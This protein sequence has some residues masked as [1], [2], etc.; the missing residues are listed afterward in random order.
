M[1]EVH[2]DPARALSDGPQAILPDQFAALVTDLR[3]LAG[4]VGRTHG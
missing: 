2:D 1:V 3:A 4:L